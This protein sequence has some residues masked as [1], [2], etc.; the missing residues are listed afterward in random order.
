MIVEGKKITAFD[1]ME[2]VMR[3]SETYH[4]NKA[5]EFASFRFSGITDIVEFH[6]GKFEGFECEIHNTYFVYLDELTCGDSFSDVFEKIEKELDRM[7][8]IE[9]EKRNEIQST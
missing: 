9:K 2:A 6:F 1:A 8:E 4:K 3:L 7:A 5:K